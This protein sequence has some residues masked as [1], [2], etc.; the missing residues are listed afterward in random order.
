M[1]ATARANTNLALIKYWGKRNE[2][3][4]LPMNS[5]LFVTLDRFFTKVTVKFCKRLTE[6]TFTV[7]QHEAGKEK[8]MKISRF[9]DIV[10]NKAGEEAFAEV[11][12]ENMVPAAAGFSSSASLYAALAAAASRA[13]GM[14]LD[15]IELS[16]LARRGS[17]PACCPVYGGFVEWQK[18]GRADG[19]DSYARQLL[20]DQD[21]K[22][23]IFSV[24]VS[25]KGKRI[26]CKEA[27]KRVVQT[28]P[29][30]QGWLQ[31]VEK[32]LRTAK[33]ALEE[34]DFNKLGRAFEANALKMHA[35]TLGASPPFTY[36]ESGTLDVIRQ[37]HDLRVKGIPVYFTI[38]TGPNVKVLCL[39]EDE[40]YVQN[41]LSSLPAVH[42]IYTCYPGSGISYGS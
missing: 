19:G 30:Y 33:E 17:G 23:S 9:L 22:L 11:T 14:E 41:R 13:L 2:K 35:T 7:N 31:S 28:S 18:G 38:D 34:R 4:N 20:S 27:M 32:D 3:L 8:T 6:D 42:D 29:F 25:T 40:H 12:C 26:S 16:K 21:W 10:R 5:S 36:W 1:Q 24:I 15:N 39:P 37:V